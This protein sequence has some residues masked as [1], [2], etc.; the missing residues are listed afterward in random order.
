MAQ[1]NPEKVPQTV[2]VE[3]EKEAKNEKKKELSFKDVCQWMRA[4]RFNQY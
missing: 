4:N 1:K 3:E 2:Q